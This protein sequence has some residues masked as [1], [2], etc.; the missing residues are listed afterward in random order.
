MYLLT[1]LELSYDIVSANNCG[2]VYWQYY[3]KQFWNG[4]MTIF[5]LRI[6]ELSNENITANYFGTDL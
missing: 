4:P 3:F 6:F 5:L 1:I 2:T